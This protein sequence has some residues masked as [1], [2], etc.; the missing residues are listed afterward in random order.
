MHAIIPLLFLLAVF[1]KLDKKYVF[2]LLPIV[3]IID[4]DLYLGD[5]HRFIFGNIFFVLLLAGVAYWA[6]DKKAFFVAMFYGVSHL[7]LDSFYGGTAWLWPIIDKTFYVV[8]SVQYEN[9]WL[10]DLGIRSLSREDYLI[11]IEDIGV[12]TY[13]SETA[14]LF[15]I[16]LGILLVAKYREEIKGFFRK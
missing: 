7:V 1:P 6:W 10:Y 12:S 4:L 9:G 8:A 11:L 2:I 15:M 16:V 14:V 13:M 5:L 3:W